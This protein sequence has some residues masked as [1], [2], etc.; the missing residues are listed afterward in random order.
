MKNCL[1][2]KYAEW[3][4][5]KSGRLHRSGEGK[6]MFVY[7][8]PKLPACMYWIMGEPKPSG[9]YINRKTEHKEHCPYYQYYRKPI[10]VSDGEAKG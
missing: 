10:E 8:I 3:E 1:N 9:K 7:N 6:C 2:C 4:T 5:D